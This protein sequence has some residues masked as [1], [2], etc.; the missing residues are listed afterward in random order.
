MKVS[1]AWWKLDRCNQTIDTLR[2]HLR[3]E[4]VT[5]WENI[6]G[7]RLKFWI[8][9]PINNLWG[10]VMLW[11]TIHDASLPLPPNRAAELIGYPADIRFTFDIEAS[12]EGNYVNPLLNKI[13]LCF[14][15]ETNSSDL[16]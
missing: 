16:I 9:D 13:G 8:S 7:M 14:E 4:G 12:I 2:S 11:E 3:N 15:T 10:A 1:I 6:K 5:S